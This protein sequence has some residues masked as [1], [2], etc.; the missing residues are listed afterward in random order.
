MALELFYTF[1]NQ[2]SKDYSEKG[3]IGTDTSITY[4]AAD[5]G[6][7]A[8]FNADTDKISVSSFTALNGLTEVSFYFRAKF[9]ATTGTK[10][11]FYKNGQFNATFDGTTLTINIIGST[12]TATVTHTPTLGTYYQY[13]ANYVHNGIANDLSLYVD[14]VNVDSTTTQ[15]ALIS[16]SNV[17]YLGGDGGGVID[18]ARFDMNEF[19]VFSNKLSEL[20]RTTHLANINGL[21]CAIPRDVYELGDILVSKPNETNKGYAIVTYVTD[22]EIRI[23]P[24]NNYVTQSDVFS[25]IGHL[26]DTTRQYSVQVTSTGINFY[27]G[28]SLS[29][30]AFT[31]A[32]L[33]HSN[34]LSSE[35]SYDLGSVGTNINNGV[36]V[37]NNFYSIL[38]TANINITGLVAQTYARRI[39]VTNRS[40]TYAITIK[41]DSSSSTSVNR[42]DLTDDFTLEAGKTIEM[43][44]DALKSRWRIINEKPIYAVY[45]AKTANY[46]ITTNDHTIDCTANTFTVTLPTAVGITGRIFNI[47][48]S[49]TG[50]ITVDTTSSQ[51]IDG[52]TSQT[53]NQYDSMAVQSTGT[54]FIII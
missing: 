19:K 53:L 4:S 49:G 36:L 38:P 35:I 22:N 11:V 2:D 18:T 45:S 21:I 33:V 32:K 5:V 31:D 54:N 16:N 8:V 44:Y 1:N 17:F 7:N 13:H 14:G 42:F 52:I 43:F 51:T 27:N 6:Y 46:T 24:L 12:G 50:V 15:G 30:E 41:N 10:Y 29:S 40:T 48:N 20:Q 34:N 28:V 25:R 26:W 39:V 3:L 47:K 37:D 9:A 23:Q